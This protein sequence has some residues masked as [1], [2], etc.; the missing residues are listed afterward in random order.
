MDSPHVRR[1]WTLQI[2]ICYNEDVLREVASMRAG[3]L[4]ARLRTSLAMPASKT[5]KN[6]LAH[7]GPG[8]SP[9]RAVGV[10]RPKL[11][12]LEKVIA[13]VEGGSPPL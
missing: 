13:F 5:W 7:R 4:K 10:D 12:P 2:R 8:P 3:K 9:H 1:R 11:K 6:S